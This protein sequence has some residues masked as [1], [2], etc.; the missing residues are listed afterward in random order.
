MI[1]S[2]IVAMDCMRGIGKGNR[3]P[4]RLSSDLKRFRAL[5]MGHHIIVG[6]KTFESI[7]RPLPGRQ[8]IVVTRNRDFKPE[9]CMIAHSL[10][11]AITLARER[12]ESEVFISG[13]ARIYARSLKLA[14]RLYLTLVHAEVGADTFFPEWDEREWIEKETSYHPADEKNEYATTFKLLQKSDAV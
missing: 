7:G 12:G 2:L 3:L 14:D 5:T 6:R 11:D 10:E 8:M 13:G 1:V 4:W 9:G